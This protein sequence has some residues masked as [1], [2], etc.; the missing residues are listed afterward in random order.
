MCSYHHHHHPTSFP[1]FGRQNSPKNNIKI[2][3]RYNQ[4]VHHW[5]DGIQYFV[6][7][8]YWRIS[9]LSNVADAAEAPSPLLL[10]LQFWPPRLTTTTLLTLLLQGLI[11]PR[12]RHRPRHSCRHKSMMM[13]PSLRE[14]KAEKKPRFLLLSLDRQEY[15]WETGLS[16]AV[17]VRLE[18]VAPISTLL[19]LLLRRMS[20]KMIAWGG[21]EEEMDG[22]GGR[23]HFSSLTL[24]SVVSRQE[25][26][27]NITKYRRKSCKYYCC[28]ALGRSV[29]FSYHVRRTAREAL[30][31][32]QISVPAL[33]YLE[34]GPMRKREV[35]PPSLSSS[36][37]CLTWY[38]ILVK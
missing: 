31:Y 37:V 13:F 11:R 18:V 25:G 29:G 14:K 28:I 22:W 21:K 27:E 24:T 12:R 34:T 9:C 3:K 4:S 19:L 17:E 2:V 6:R 33:H 36:S 10:L 26:E 15:F 38:A 7:N 20:P 16:W 5:E 1:S 23:T 8:T 30:Q 32:W 35:L